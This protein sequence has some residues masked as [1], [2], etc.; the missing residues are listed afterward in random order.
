MIAWNRAI[1]MGLLA[2]WC[3]RYERMSNRTSGEGRF[4]L[5]GDLALGFYQDSG[6]GRPLKHRSHGE[7]G[8]RCCTPWG[9]CCF[10]CPA[11]PSLMLSGFELVLRSF[12]CFPTSPAE[13]QRPSSMLFSPFSVCLWKVALNFSSMGKVFPREKGIWHMLP[14]P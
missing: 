13:T 1:L 6:Q 11:E 9:V 10:A 12:A 2:P 8:A 3:V 5:R 14:F 7:R 4:V